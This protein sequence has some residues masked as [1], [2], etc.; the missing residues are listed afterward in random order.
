MGHKV[1]IEYVLL[2]GVNDREIDAHAMGRLFQHQQIKHQVKKSWWGTSTSVK[3][4][5]ENENSNPNVLDQ[6][7]EISEKA[8]KTFRKGS[9]KRTKNGRLQVQIPEEDILYVV[10]EAEEDENFSDER[11]TSED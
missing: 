3:L 10:P 8:R 2:H 1:L 9:R 11:T 4:E 5:I 6:N 7:S